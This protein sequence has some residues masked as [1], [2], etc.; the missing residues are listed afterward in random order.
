MFSS[1]GIALDVLEK[2]VDLV[3]EGLVAALPP[4]T[5]EIISR[6]MLAGKS[7][8]SGPLESTLLIYRPAVAAGRSCT[9]AT[10][11]PFLKETAAVQPDW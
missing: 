11:K 9:A 10:S 6:Y 2:N 3:R 8:I 4:E 1:Y 7:E 5:H